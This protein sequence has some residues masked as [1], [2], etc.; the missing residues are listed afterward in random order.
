MAE[1]TVPEGELW[2]V[3]AGVVD[4]N[5]GGNGDTAVRLYA[6][7]ANPARTGYNKYSSERSSESTFDGTVKTGSCTAAVGTYAV[8]GDTVGISFNTNNFT[9]FD[10]HYALLIRRVL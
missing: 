1:A 6:G 8:P 4:G 2:Y 10:I 9:A 3:D 7:I 5:S